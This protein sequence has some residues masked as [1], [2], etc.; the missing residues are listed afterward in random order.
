[1]SGGKD[2]G[3]CFGVLRRENCV[4]SSVSICVCVCVFVY[5]FGEEDSWVVWVSGKGKDVVH[6]VGVL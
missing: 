5:L 1:M 3:H 6:R 4:K 2:V